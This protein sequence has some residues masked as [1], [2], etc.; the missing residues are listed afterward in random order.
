MNGIILTGPKHCGKTSAGRALASLLSCEFIDLDELIQKR[1]GKSPRELYKES[2][3][4]FQNAETEALMFLVK[5]AK[6]KI[7][8]DMFGFDT[9]QD[10]P[11]EGYRV[12]AAGG[13]IIDNSKACELLRDIQIDIIFINISAN[14]AWKRIEVSG[15]LPPFLKTDN[16]RE[17]HRVLHERRSAAYLE[18]ANII[19][20]AE[21]LGIDE[22]ANRIFNCK[23]G[24]V[25]QLS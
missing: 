10:N 2:P 1:T 11:N 20:D 19:I 25:R 8:P 18:L 23:N 12:I 3:S 5:S 24:L 15:E 17:T 13:G 9:E 22:I 6:K 7:S 16:P 14:T 4:V 21:G